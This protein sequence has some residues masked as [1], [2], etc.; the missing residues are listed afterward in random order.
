MT[1]VE[2]DELASVRDY[3]RQLEA[4]AGTKVR[5]SLSLEERIAGRRRL[6][7]G[8]WA[9]GLGVALLAGAGMAASSGDWWSNEGEARVTA[10]PSNQSSRSVSKN[11]TSARVGQALTGV[12]PQAPPAPVTVPEETPA[13]APS[14]ARLPQKGAQKTELMPR[15][16]VPADS[17]LA[18]Q[19]AQLQAAMAH[20]NSADERAVGELR[21]F[22]RRWPGSALAHE[23]DIE[24]VAALRRLG[25]HDESRNAARDFIRAHPESA[26]T[27]EMKA[28]ANGASTP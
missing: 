6:A 5:T 8:R 19:V 20:L 7:P 23:A 9:L 15:Q 1:M 16:E 22:K 25:R 2:D 13:S 27:R 3:L 11:M 4:P 12:R 21:A 14:H 18:Q 10:A 28:L 24:I 26:K 17:S